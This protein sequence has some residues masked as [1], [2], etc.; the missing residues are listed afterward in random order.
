M[1]V[2][3]PALD[4]LS[5]I[6]GLLGQSAEGSLP[7]DA[8][9]IGVTIAVLLALSFLL[10]LIN[11]YKRCPANMIL[12]VSGRVGKG[13]S[14]RCQ[15][16]GAAFIWPLL[17]EFDWLSLEP[18][19]IEVRLNDA[20]SSE[21]IRVNV[22]SVFTVAIGTEEEFMYNAA[23]R[24]LG[25]TNAES[26]KQ[27]QDI[28]FGQLRHVIASMSIQEINRDRDKFLHSIQSALAPELKKLGLRLINVNITDITDASGYIEAIGQKAAA[29]A[30]QQARA[31]VAEQEKL[32]EIRVAEA[33]RDKDVAVADA[34][35]IREIGMREAERDQAVRVADLERE[36]KVAEEAARFKEEAQ[37]AASEQEKRIAVANANATAVD[38]EN[39]AAAKIALSKAELTVKEAE[40]YQTGE[41]RKKEAEAAVL[42]VENRAQARA[43]L[44]EAER[45][46]AE[47]RA[48]LE[49]PAKAKKAE[50]IVEAEAEAEKRR[51]EAEGEAS[52]I[53]AKLEAEAKGLYET[54]AKKGEGLG[55]IIQAT[56]G[57]KEA[58][59][60]LLLEHLDTLAETSAKAISQIKFDKVV[61]WEGG[62]GKEGEG[63]QT[64]QFLQ[65]LSRTL[66]PM[67]HVMKD[68]GGVE[69]PDQLVRLQGL[70]EAEAGTDAATPATVTSAGSVT[71]G[72]EADDD[73]SSSTPSS[74]GSTASSKS[75][76][77]KRS[78]RTKKSGG[79]N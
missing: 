73:S 34:S 57:A 76:A 77:S 26:Q 20:L 19:Q 39:E 74:G 50:T 38:G 15:N 42:E 8:V 18:M 61:V 4:S 60:L 65:N 62:R 40:A 17:Q 43:A 23:T 27:A 21:N 70:A 7:A 10:L 1:F 31:D 53:F 14:S 47:R 71:D 25:L 49:A 5:P 37:I 6:V 3:A 48:E 66:P 29:T 9:V 51:I 22:P 33:N 11:R 36:Q 32:G 44:A 52:A 54:L 72:G 56:G 13:R 55:Q 79:S 16:G 75:A 69:L 68:I 64:S 2:S 30:V 35:K 67:L 63:S 41:S 12:V 59:Q 45:V 28:L 46:E 24:L 78:S 58:F